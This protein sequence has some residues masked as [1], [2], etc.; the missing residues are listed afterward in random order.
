[1][2]IQSKILLFRQKFLNLAKKSIGFNDQPF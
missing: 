1:M 2:F